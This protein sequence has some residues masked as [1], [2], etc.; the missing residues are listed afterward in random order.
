MSY[1]LPDEVLAI[2]KKL[3]AEHR[4]VHRGATMK[5]VDGEM[6]VDKPG[7]ITAVIIDKTLGVEYC[8]AEGGD[9]P[10]AVVNA[11]RKALTADKPMTPAQKASVGQISTAKASEAAAR[12][13]LAKAHAELAAL[14]ASIAGENASKSTKP[15]KG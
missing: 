8:Q 14:K 4:I 12:D 1:Q 7:A 11:Y 5:K 2:Q 6:V 15:V 10:E 3:N 13:E 9:E